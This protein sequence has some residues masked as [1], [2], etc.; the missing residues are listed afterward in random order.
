MFYICHRLNRPLCF[1]QHYRDIYKEESN[2]YPTI[3][4]ESA[5]NLGSTDVLRQSLIDDYRD[6]S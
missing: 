4:V 3:E 1:D 5:T 2:K 6:E